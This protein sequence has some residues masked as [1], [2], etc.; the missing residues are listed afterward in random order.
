MVV[1]HI[2][3]AYKEDNMQFAWY[4]R[5]LYIKQALHL[6]CISMEQK[7]HMQ[8]GVLLLLI[9]VDHDNTLAGT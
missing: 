4:Q 3:Q 1:R 5:I 2:T 7:K 8:G 6:N 9:S